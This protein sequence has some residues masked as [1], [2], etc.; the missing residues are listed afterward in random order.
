MSKMQIM[1]D[2]L[3]TKHSALQEEIDR[4]DEVVKE[5]S[6]KGRLLAQSLDEKKE[7]QGHIAR[8]ISNLKAVMEFENTEVQTKA[9]AEDPWGDAY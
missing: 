9:E 6:Q 1:I 8:A 2:E 5:L 3:E 4:D 7:R